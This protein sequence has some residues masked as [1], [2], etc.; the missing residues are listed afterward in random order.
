MLSGSGR[1]AVVFN[2]EIFNYRELRAE[3]EANGHVFHSASDTEVLL[4][5]YIEWKEQCL[6]RLNGMWAFIILDTVSGEC[7][8]SR[9]RFGIK[10]LY[11][12]RTADRV[13][14]ASEAQAIVRSGL[15][16]AQ[17]DRQM[18]ARYLFFGD[19][20]QGV[21]TF[22]EGIAAVG[23]GTWLSINREGR[24]RS[25]RYWELP[26]DTDDGEPG[27]SGLYDVFHD[28]VRLRLQS[29]VPVG[30][31]LSGGLD[32][33]SILCSAAR[34]LGSSRTLNAY[35]FMSPEYDESRYI[36]DTI[37]QTGATLIP[38]EVDNGRLWEQLVQMTRFQDGPV[39][40]PSALIGFCLC[41]L[42]AKWGTK[43]VLNGQ[44]AD[45]TWAGYS[46][47][48][49]VYWQAL[50]AQARFGRLLAQLRQY[51]ARHQIGTLALMRQV[52]AR[53]V[54]IQL[55]RAK[56]Y[57]WAAGIRHRADWLR[58]PLYARALGESLPRYRAYGGDRSFG[59]MLRQSVTTSALPLYMRVEDRNS[60]AHSIEARLPFLDHRL[61][62][63]IMRI[64]ATRKLDGF[65]NKVL[66]REAMRGYIPE[67]VRTRPDKMGFA[68]PDAKWIRAWAPNIEEI[69]HSRSFA[70]RDFFNI[71]SLLGAL[72][73]HVAGIRDRHE[74]IFRAV[75]VELCL[76]ATEC[77]A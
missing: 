70:E 39:H 40:T 54:R 67:S 8:C 7:F 43:V 31:F 64:A 38:L 21:R 16:D 42:A 55:N 30:T 62:T 6:E 29:D 58:H 22:H 23:P 3:L 19:L 63:A 50:L 72:H 61:V 68:T 59:E 49:G 53:S 28:S 52:I 12:L 2:G 11:W 26:E 33:T 35:A 73:D 60:M 34:E 18:V 47:Y 46:G 66:L 17:V 36:G 74:D 24:V 77:A 14:L 65:W 51:G 32:S 45:E 56:P 69:F 71:P 20:D 27:L 13:I 25:G 75:Q 57:R 37:N 41:G 1:Y 9:D 48:F 10:P 76:R 5:A 44:G 4:E 15:Y